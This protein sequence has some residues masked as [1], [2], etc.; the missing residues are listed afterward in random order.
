MQS[1]HELLEATKYF[2]AAQVEQFPGSPPVQVAQEGSQ[3]TQ[4]APTF[5]KP[6]NAQGTQVLFPLYKYNPV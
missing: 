5:A 3:A 4:L 6:S 2:P 1:T